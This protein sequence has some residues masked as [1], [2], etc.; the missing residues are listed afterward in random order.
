MLKLQTCSQE[1][2]KQ[3]PGG[4]ASDPAGFQKAVIACINR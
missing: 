4:I 2:A 1:V 3:F